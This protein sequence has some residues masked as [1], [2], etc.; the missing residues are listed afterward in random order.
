[1]GNNTYP[2]TAITSFPGSGNTWFRHLIH[3]ATGYHTGSVYED[4]KLI[5]AGFQ[6]EKLPWYSKEI[7]GVKVHTMGKAKKLVKEF[8]HEVSISTAFPK[9]IMI[10]RSP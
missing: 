6:G 1:M 4:G 7:L 3:M 9:T 5:D 2:R 10:I 8:D